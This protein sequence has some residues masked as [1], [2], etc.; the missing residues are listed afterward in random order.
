MQKIVMATSLL[1]VWVSWQWGLTAI[2]LL[3]LLSCLF[4]IYWVLMMWGQVQ[5][6]ELE[7]GVVYNTHKK[8]FVRFLPSGRHRLAPFVEQVQATIPL[9]SGSASDRTSGVQT[10]GGIALDVAWTVSY[11]L[12][13]FC[14]AADKQAKL[15][16]SLPTKAASVVTKHMGN[17]LQ[18]VLG[19]H[20]VAQLV[21]PGSHKRLERELRQC[22]AERLADSGFEVSRVM[23]GAIAM[24]APVRKALE[25]AE[26]R[27]LQTENEVQALSRFQQVIS[28]FSDAE[29]QR[30][31]ELE[32]IHALGQH[33][34]ALYYPGMVEEKTAVF[35]LPTLS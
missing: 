10:S 20:T 34:V 31:L 27:R 28:R 2:L 5:I 12:N 30:L 23:I 21:Q 9:T 17:C 3:T 26:E 11:T 29:V 35:P 22:L 16:R 24:P 4:A 14:I 33:G 15:A 8:Q 32:R 18:H 1:F 19:D 25:A 13:P 7:A 6:P